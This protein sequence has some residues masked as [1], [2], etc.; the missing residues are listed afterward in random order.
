MNYTKSLLWGAILALVIP[1]LPARG[2]GAELTAGKP[3]P[4]FTFTSA[5]GKSTRLSAYRGK[6]VVLHFW[7]TWC[8]PCIRELPL[9]SALTTAKA[10]EL[11]VL[12]VNCAETDR[13]VSAFLGR[14]QLALNVVMDRDYRIAQLY[15]V[16]AIP[17]TYLIDKAGMI[18]TVRVGAYS[19]VELN[20][21]IAALLN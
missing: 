14:S 12:A 7:T 10:E 4:D 8:G 17:Q 6:P 19:R 2:Q 21:D 1:G 20:Q 9:I 11:T 5:A 16:N 15:R 13:E 3:A 18:Q